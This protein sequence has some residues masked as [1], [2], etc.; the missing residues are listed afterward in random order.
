MLIGSNLLEALSL[1]IRVLKE[2]NIGHYI[3]PAPASTIHLTND[4]KIRGTLRRLP[5]NNF[6]DHHLHVHYHRL[7]ISSA[8]QMI[9][10]GGA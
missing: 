1:N 6:E 8:Q 10:L 4:L 3:R 2:S 9:I 5:I 7:S